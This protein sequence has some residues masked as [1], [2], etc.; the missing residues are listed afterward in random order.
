M[1]FSTDASLKT[2]QFQHS[3]WISAFEYY[4]IYHF[5]F[6]RKKTYILSCFIFMCCM[7]R[8]FELKFSSDCDVIN[9]PMLGKYGN[10]L[11][12][13]KLVWHEFSLGTIEIANKRQ[14]NKKEWIVPNLPTTISIKHTGIDM[15][16][17]TEQQQQQKNAK[18]IIVDYFLL[19]TTIPLF[20]PP[21]S[22]FL[23]FN[24]IWCFLLFKLP[25]VYSIHRWM[26]RR[27]N[28]L[29]LFF[30]PFF[31]S[32]FIYSHLFS[33]TFVLLFEFITFVASLNPTIKR[34]T[35]EV[36]NVCA[37]VCGVWRGMVVSK[38]ACTRN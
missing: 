2:K 27:F 24:K 11:F 37:C 13:W 31:L 21:K 9:V 6:C 4:T 29:S 32:L 26:W 12:I 15:Y 30:L 7:Y 8:M 1:S 28:T 16:V 22:T 23:L 20:P 18:S 10:T 19:Y 17:C 38:K 14:Q 36:N 33:L 35:V 5:E 25:Y 34:V 3:I